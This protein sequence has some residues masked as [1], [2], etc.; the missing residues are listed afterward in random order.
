MAVRS[1]ELE[2]QEWA[3]FRETEGTSNDGW[4]VD[5]RPSPSVTAGDT[6]SRLNST[7]FDDWQDY[8][9]SGKP[10]QASQNNVHKAKVNGFVYSEEEMDASLGSNS[11]SSS[12]KKEQQ[13]LASTD[14]VRK[15]MEECYPSVEHKP[16]AITTTVS[17]NTTRL[18]SAE[19]KRSLTPCLC[20]S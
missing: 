14:A 9:S 3:V 7:E 4:F 8:S 12:Q 2:Q 15:V 16:T 1:D 20:D 5:D 13:P 10:L 19:D 11:S 18:L 6:T 17:T